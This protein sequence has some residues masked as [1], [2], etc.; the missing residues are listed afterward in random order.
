MEKK[1]KKIL[2]IGGTSGGGV[3][4]INNEVIKI[5][6]KAG[7]EYDLIDTEKMKSRFLAPIAYLLAYIVSFFRIVGRRPDL[8]YLQCAQTGYMHQSFFLLIAKILGRETVAHFHAKADLK[9]TTTTSQF[10]RILFSEKY[11][12]R[13]ILLTRPCMDCLLENGW[14]KKTFVIPNFISTE[15]LP[16]V[17]EL[18][19]RR[20]LFLY[21]GRMN[22]E[23]G[24]YEILEAA[25][26]LKD[27]K[28]VFVGNID[29]DA[30]KKRF[31]EELDGIENAEWRGPLYGDEKYGIIAESKF[32]LF[33]TK[34]DEFPMTLIESTILGCVPLVS[35][36]GSVGEIIKDGYNGFYIS[37]DDIDGIVEKI[38]EWKDNP[39]LRK[40]SENGIEYARRN[41]TSQAVEDKLLGIVG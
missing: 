40:V 5:F 17:I 2:F 34:R 24:I 14:K 9:G 30:D 8:V 11:T 22:W 7:Y 32:L 41:F 19:D 12:D 36:I 20:K 33:P 10:N 31:T 38:R 23:K 1:K 4:T 18:A 6:D 27:E 28:F 3:A 16:T 39:D 26:C 13:M 37:P 29:N 21:L 25:K 15:D 35:L